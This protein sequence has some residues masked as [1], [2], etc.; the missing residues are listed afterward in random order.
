M[1]FGEEYYKFT[2]VR[3]PWDAV[4]SMH[5]YWKR[6]K[7]VVHYFLLSKINFKNLREL[8]EKVERIFF[9]EKVVKQICSSLSG[10]WLDVNGKPFCDDYIRF[11]KLQEDYDCVCKKIGFKSKKLPRLRTKPNRHKK[12]YSKYYNKR[13][14]EIVEKAFQKE[15]EY[16]GYKFEKV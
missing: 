9:S 16:F 8:I 4:F 14:K 7:N 11:E 1:I 6:K 5:Q 13:K 3:N 10:Y 2:I 12:H 15:I